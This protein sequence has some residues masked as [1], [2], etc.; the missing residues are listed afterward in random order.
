MDQ[1]DPYIS[2][3]LSFFY[4]VFYLKIKTNHNI[5]K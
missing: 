4:C 2:S 5:Y 3:F 1:K